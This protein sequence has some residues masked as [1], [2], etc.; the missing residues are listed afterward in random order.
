MKARDNSSWNMDAYDY[1]IW[2]NRAI[3]SLRARRTGFPASACF[4]AYHNANIP[5]MRPSTPIGIEEA[6]AAISPDVRPPDD[7]LELDGV[8]AI[9]FPVKEA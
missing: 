8:T 6:S 5:R 1:V 2:R 4:L 3:S 9:P 7:I